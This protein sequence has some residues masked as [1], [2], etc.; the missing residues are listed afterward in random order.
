[1]K[2]INHLYQIALC[3]LLTVFAPCMGFTQ[4]DSESIIDVTACESFFWHGT[5]Y[6]ESGTYTYSYDDIQVDTLHLTVNYGTHNVETVTACD[7]YAWK[8]MI[9]TISGS[10]TYSYTNALGCPSV[11]TLHLTIYPSFILQISETICQSELPYHYLNGEIDT[12]FETGTPQSSE[13]DFVLST[14]NGCDSVISLSLTVVPS[15][16]ERKS[17]LAKTHADGT[18]YMLVYPQSGLIYQWYQNGD[19]IAGATNQYFVPEEDLETS[20][21]CYRVKVLL[22]NSDLCG[23]MTDCWVKTNVSAAK[24]SILPNPNDGRFKLLMPSDATSVRIFNANGQLVFEQETILESEIDVNTNFADGFYIV[25]VFRENG[26]I[27]IEKLV[28]NR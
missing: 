23:I 25:K 19:A 26:E 15:S 13:V 5:T 17:V 9:Y 1:M 3:L 6:T 18:P 10:Y 8:G 4:S 11:D 16:L 24:V 21:F 20:T 28:I 12:T 2:Y 22:Q 7:V 14:V 27:N